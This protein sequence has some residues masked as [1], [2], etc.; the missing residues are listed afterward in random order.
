MP[1]DESQNDGR[2][3]GAIRLVRAASPGAAIE[4][5]AKVARIA[6]MSRLLLEETRHGSLDE[7]SRRRL[8]QIYETSVREL[9]GNLS[10]DL[11]TELQRLSITFRD[12]T[13][14]AAEARLAQAQ[15]VGWLDGLANG[16][17]TDMFAQEVAKESQLA[18]T[19]SR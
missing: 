14:S 6:A 19:S 2:R 4:R 16:I 1:Q 5:P 12:G 15:L 8:G 7:A 11:T 10:A 18:V 3:R 9:A 17:Q 13:P